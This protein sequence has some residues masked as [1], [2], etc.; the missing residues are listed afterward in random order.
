[1]I[2]ESKH[3]F[4]INKKVIKLYEEDKDKTQREREQVEVVLE[5]IEILK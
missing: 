1:M 5:W 4:I 2:L 3:L